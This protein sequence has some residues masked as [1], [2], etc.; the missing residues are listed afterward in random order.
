MD[1]NGLDWVSGQGPMASFCKHGNESSGS[2]KSGE[3]LDYLSVLLYSRGGICGKY[4]HH[5]YRYRVYN[6]EMQ[7]VVRIP[8]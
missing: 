5:S 4:T 1:L 2:I 7:K 6:K 8:T 3:F